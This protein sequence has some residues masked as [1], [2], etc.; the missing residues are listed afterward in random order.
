MQAVLSWSPNGRSWCIVHTSS[1]H[2]NTDKTM[3]TD[4][5]TNYDAEANIPDVEKIKNLFEKNFDGEANNK[6][7][8][9]EDSYM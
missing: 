9:E 6:Q 1:H 8:D 3:T 2:E 7:L 5:R 4:F